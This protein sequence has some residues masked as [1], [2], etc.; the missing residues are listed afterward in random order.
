MSGLARGWRMARRCIDILRRDKSL[1]AFPV[2]SAVACSVAFTLLAAP[3]VAWA[4]AIDAWW[5]LVPFGALALYA[6][7]YFAVYFNVALAVAVS[8]SLRGREA[9]LADGL[10]GARARR[11]AIARWAL[12]QTTVGVLL[13]TLQALASST[14]AGRVVVPLVTRLAGATWA[15]ASFFVI[16]VLA[17]EGVGPKDALRRSTRLVRERW[18]EGLG[19]TGAIA[20]TVLLVGLVPAILLVA[21]AAG[22][23]GTAAPAV[24]VAIAVLLV[25][26]AG[27]TGA[28]L[29]AIFRVAL[30]DFARDGGAVAGFDVGELATAVAKPARARVAS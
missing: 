23:G 21:L 18:G 29:S 17:F 12:L 30:Y 14:G 19:G 1:V 7:T 15:I 13:H 11:G 25:I 10:A 26:V 5:P 24:L 4:A 28:A 2:L 3:G 22:I 16:P 8:E 6:A 20:L 27:V 9:H